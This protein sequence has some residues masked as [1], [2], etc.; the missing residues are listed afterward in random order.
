M[1]ASKQYFTQ[2]DR[3]LAQTLGQTL[4]QQK[5]SNCVE[6]LESLKPSPGKQ[7]WQA[8][9]T[10]S[11]IYIVLT[12]KVR[13]L[14]RADNLITSLE[15]GAS[16]GELTLFRGD[17]FQPYAA[18]ASVNLQLYYLR[19]EYLQALIRR[20]PAI[21]EHLYHQAV[22]WD[23]LL[24]LRQNDTLRDRPIEA[25]MKLRSL[26]KRH[27]LEIGRL[28]ASL[29]KDRQLWPIRRGQILHSAGQKL[30]AGKIYI[31]SQ[32]TQDNA[33]RVRGGSAVQRRSLL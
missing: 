15:P 20:Y 18:R 32:L 10:E 2:L 19:G 13:L 33:W 11:G 4:S 23:L 9:D 5:L 3:Q 29:L 17:D 21:R 7:F 30:T 28:P 14:D 8:A 26:L 25:L 12:G 27:D 1:V 16:F 22:L 24:L 31:S 6:R